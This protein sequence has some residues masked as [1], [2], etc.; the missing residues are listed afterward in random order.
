M[1]I[2]KYISH[3]RRR[4][5]MAG[6]DPGSALTLGIV[7][8]A[9]LVGFAI[10]KLINP[11]KPPPGS[12]TAGTGTSLTPDQAAADAKAQAN[13]PSWSPT[14]YATWAAAIQ[15]EGN[16][17]FPSSGP[18][19][20]QIFNEYM[21][22]MADVLSLIAAFG[23]YSPVDLGIQE[24]FSY[25]LPTWLWAAFK[26]STVAAINTQLQQNGVNYSF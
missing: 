12:T 14:Q 11:K 3:K 6:I 21:D 25:N 1:A 26:D 19:T 23:N 13:A 18:N 24:A 7:V 22:N 5:H 4:R 20:I 17:V 2:V 9:G 15:A 10:Y 8:V 16:R